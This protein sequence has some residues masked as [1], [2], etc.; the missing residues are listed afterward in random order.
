LVKNPQFGTPATA[1]I[2]KNGLNFRT[3]YRVPLGEKSTIATTSEFTSTEENWG[4]RDRSG[5]EN[6]SMAMGDRRVQ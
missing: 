4:I 3:K 6:S 1:F 5:S 2:G